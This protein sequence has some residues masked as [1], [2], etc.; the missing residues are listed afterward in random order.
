[1][2]LGGACSAS[3]NALALTAK[4]EDVLAPVLNS[5]ALPVLLLSGILLPISVA[6]GAPQWLA[7]VSDFMPTKYI[8][9]AIRETFTGD[10][11]N[12]TTF[13]GIVWTLVLFFAGLWV[14]TRT[15]RKDNV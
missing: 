6:T 3:S 1:M 14:G 5:I 7:T 8:V 11:W 9:N 13:W 12:I 2:L 4:S 15:F 10:F